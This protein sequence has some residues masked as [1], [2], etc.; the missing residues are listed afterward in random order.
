[1]NSLASSQ[2]LLVAHCNL[3]FFSTS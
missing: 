2:F 3:L 1:M